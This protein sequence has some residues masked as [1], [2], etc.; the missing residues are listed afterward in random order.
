MVLQDREQNGDSVYHSPALFYPYIL[1]LILIL[2]SKRC[3]SLQQQTKHIGY[4]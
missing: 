2:C 1:S 4:V 3:F